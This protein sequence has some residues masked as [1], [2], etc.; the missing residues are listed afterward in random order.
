MKDG[1][2][3]VTIGSEISGGVRYVFAERCEMDSP[4]LDRALRLKTNAMRGGVLEHIYM[5]DVTI[6]QVA[7]AVV[8]V[9]FHY[10]EGATGSH[11]PTVRDIEVQNVTSRKSEHALYLRGFANA[12]ITNVRLVNC[13]FDDVAKANVLEYVTGLE[14]IDVRINGQLVRTA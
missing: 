10:E 14:M 5:R 8:H 9:D 4:N 3:G 12:P 7:D 2:G 11:L 1:H 6:G 13:R